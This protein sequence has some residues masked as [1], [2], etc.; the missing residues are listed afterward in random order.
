MR[1]RSCTSAR[2]LLGI[3]DAEACEDDGRDLVHPA[4]EVP[5]RMA[6]RAYDPAERARQKQAS[7]DQ[8]ARDLASGQKSREALRQENGCLASVR[9]RVSFAGAKSLA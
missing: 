8:D 3:Q 7:R 9:I 1:A 4:A 5:A 6:P 2:D